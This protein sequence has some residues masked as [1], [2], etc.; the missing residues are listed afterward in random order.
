M[1]TI[2]LSVLIV[3]MLSVAS[4]K[5][6]RFSDKELA[7]RREAFY[8]PIPSGKTGEAK[9]QVTHASTGIRTLIKNEFIKL[10]QPNV[11]TLEFYGNTV[12]YQLE[13]AWYETNKIDL[14]NPNSKKE[15]MVT[16]S[17]GVFE[18][19]PQFQARINSEQ[20]VDLIIRDIAN[21]INSI[22]INDKIEASET[23]KTRITLVRTA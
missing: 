5:S 15:T 16:S 6:I 7:F 21:Q 13:S 18:I 8:G 17:R 1:R 19:R 9:F 4:A 11:L 14:S 22:D 10:D 23:A 2:I 3:C 12:V 20:S